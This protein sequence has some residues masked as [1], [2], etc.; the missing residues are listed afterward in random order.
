MNSSGSASSTTKAAVSEG[1]LVIR[2][3]ANQTQNVADLSRDAAGAN[4]GLDKNLRQGER[5]A[6]NGN[7]AAAGGNRLAGGGYCPDA[8]GDCGDESRHG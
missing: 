2:D 8:G 6:A 5:A 7:G 4:P 1:T 3:G